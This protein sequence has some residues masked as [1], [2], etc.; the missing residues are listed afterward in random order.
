MTQQF[1][2]FI[3][4]DNKTFV[5]SNIDWGEYP[6]ANPKLFDPATV[7]FP[8]AQAPCTACWDGYLCDFEIK[9]SS[10]Y[11]KNL[12]INLIQEDSRRMFG[13]LPNSDIEGPEFNGVKPIFRLAMPDTA[14]APIC[15]GMGGFNNKYLN[16]MHKVNLNV[17]HMVIAAGKMCS[18]YYDRYEGVYSAFSYKFVYK[19]G[20]KEGN[21]VDLIDLSSTA[22]SFRKLLSDK[23]IDRQ[24]SLFG[25]KDP[26]IYNF[27]YYFDLISTS[28]HYR[29]YQ[30]NKKACMYYSLRPELTEEQKPNISD[31]VISWFYEKNYSLDEIK[32]TKPGDVIKT[33]DFPIA[34]SFSIGS[35]VS[36]N[37]FDDWCTFLVQNKTS[38][39]YGEVVKVPTEDDKVLHIKLFPKKGE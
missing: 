39:P 6:S 4:M 35:L 33:T 21:I 36:I 23:K 24:S 9:D 28:D 16:V 29:G 11:V 31:R 1:R 12:Y 38:D 37:G 26:D 18:D 8:R 2:N 14:T 17:T 20:I 3:E 25:I 34:D 15:T 30:N 13:N 19:F 10:F 7:G 5:I 22:E 27:P 32:N